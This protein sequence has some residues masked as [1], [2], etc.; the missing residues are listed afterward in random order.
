MP[1]AFARLRLVK[2]RGR[3][4]GRGETL[5]MGVGHDEEQGG[6]GEA[7]TVA[8]VAGAREMRALC[9]SV[10]RC[11]CVTSAGVRYVPVEAHTQTQQ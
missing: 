1:C 3:R 10:Y 6:T 4:R 5:C 8:K 2:S 9:G 11:V 7:K